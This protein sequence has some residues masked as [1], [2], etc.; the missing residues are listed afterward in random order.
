MFDGKTTLPSCGKV[1]PTQNV[2]SRAPVQSTAA[3]PG[4]L[5]TPR[6][7]SLRGTTKNQIAATPAI[8]DSSESAWSQ[9][10]P[11]V[12]SRT[13]G[14]MAMA[15]MAARAA[16]RATRGTAPSL[17]CPPTHGPRPGCGCA[18]CNTAPAKYMCGNGR[19]SRWGRPGAVPAD[20][21][22][23]TDGNREGRCSQPGGAGRQP[24]R[25]G[26]PPATGVLLFPD[27][28]C[29]SFILARLRVW[30]LTSGQTRWSPPRDGVSPARKRGSSTRPLWTAT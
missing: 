21:G 25:L 29:W 15:A 27:S 30:H 23:S 9:A 13:W 6:G 19:G 22:S 16:A 2:N 18:P 26:A 3:I 1:T 17:H 24:G 7:E 5:L 4:A 14:M 10:A 11:F 20:L 12:G 8:K 28:G